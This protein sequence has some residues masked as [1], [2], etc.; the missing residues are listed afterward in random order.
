[1]LLMK[2]FLCSIHINFAWWIENKSNFQEFNFRGKKNWIL[3]IKKCF[4]FD[5]MV[6]IFC[7][8][9]VKVCI[10]NIENYSNFFSWKKRGDFT[11]LNS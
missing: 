9:Y 10:I 8:M 1:M 3:L 5:I 7:I 4:L 6:F 11:K 2:S